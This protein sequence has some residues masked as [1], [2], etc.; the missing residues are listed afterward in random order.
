MADEKKVVAPAATEV[1]A[2]APKPVTENVSEKEWKN[3]NTVSEDFDEE[4]PF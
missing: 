4:L 3:L 1:K 2:E